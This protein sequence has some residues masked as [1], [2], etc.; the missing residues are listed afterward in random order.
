[1]LRQILKEKNEKA[2]KRKEAKEAW[3]AIQQQRKEERERRR[4]EK[5]F[6]AELDY[7]VRSLDKKLK[8]A[9]KKG[10]DYLT[11]YKQ[12]SFISHPPT[13]R[14]HHSNFFGNHAPFYVGKSPNELDRKVLESRW[15]DPIC[16]AIVSKLDDEKI[17]FRLIETANYNELYHGS[18]DYYLNVVV[19]FTRIREGE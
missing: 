1:M 10:L 19:D 14:L 3:K 16:L 15:V 9:A 17:P 6:N 7:E 12:S 11:V 18:Q 8:K 5:Q 4:R 2:A 13:P